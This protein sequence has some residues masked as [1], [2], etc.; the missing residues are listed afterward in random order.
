V[1][2]IV[3]VNSTDVVMPPKALIVPSTAEDL[4]GFTQVPSSA[5]IIVAEKHRD[6]TIAAKKADVKM[7]FVGMRAPLTGIVIEHDTANRL[8]WAIMPIEMDRLMQVDGL[9]MPGHIQRN[10][11]R[12]RELGLFDDFYIAHA[13]NQEE[14]SAET[15][16]TIRGQVSSEMVPWQAMKSPMMRRMGKFMDGSENLHFALRKGFA[17]LVVATGNT[18]VRILI[19]LALLAFSA[20]FAAVGAVAIGVFF[21]VAAVV[22]VAMA[23]GAVIGMLGSG[24]DPILYGVVSVTDRHGKPYKMLYKIGQWDVR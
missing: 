14:V 1:K 5:Q 18:T 8:G 20:L 11:K 9:Q 12:A 17:R 6:L 4:F 10:F 21:A 2:Q 13:W 3:Q 16:L 23:G 24:V 7:K 22:G 15:A 19:G